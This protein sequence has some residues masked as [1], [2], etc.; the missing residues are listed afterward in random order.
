MCRDT[1]TIKF[2]DIKT[3]HL[4]RFGYLA[5]STVMFIHNLMILFV[6]SLKIIQR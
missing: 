5:C 4:L 2:I 6:A 1:I 3:L